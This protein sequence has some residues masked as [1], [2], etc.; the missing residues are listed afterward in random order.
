MQKVLIEANYTPDGVKGLLQ[1]GG[2][3][4]QKTVEELVAGLG[5]RL[6]S[7]YYALGSNDVY[8]VADLPDLVTATALSMVINATGAVSLRTVVLLT[9]QEVDQATRKTVDYRPPG[10]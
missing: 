4:R 5:G 3:R 7:F 8:A 6:E 1:E 2:S 10:A 9:A